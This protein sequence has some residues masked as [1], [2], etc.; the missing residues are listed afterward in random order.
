MKRLL[1]IIV[2]L[3]LAVAFS[4]PGIAAP[5]VVVVS[6]TAVGPNEKVASDRAARKLQRQI[7]YWAHVNQLSAV[8]V[9]AAH[10]VC[11][12]G[13]AGLYSCTSSARVELNPQPELRS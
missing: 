4:A 9:G 10:T 8:R 6:V 13:A 3:G 2:A 12:T 1:S 11:T 7:N 5:R